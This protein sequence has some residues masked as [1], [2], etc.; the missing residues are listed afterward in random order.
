MTSTRNVIAL[1]AVALVLSVGACIACI[2]HASGWLAPI[3]QAIAQIIRAIG[4]NS[5]EPDYSPTRPGRHSLRPGRSQL[6]RR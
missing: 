3:L 4:A 2:P 1:S 6:R 5:A